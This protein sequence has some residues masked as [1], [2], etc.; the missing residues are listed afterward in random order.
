MPAFL[1]ENTLKFFVTEYGLKPITFVSED[2]RATLQE[3]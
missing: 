3:K 2:L 1:T